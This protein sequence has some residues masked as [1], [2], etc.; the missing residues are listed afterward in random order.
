MRQFDINLKSLI[1]SSP[2]VIFLCKLTG[3]WPVELITENV[4]QFGYETE[5][6]ISG[7]IQFLDIV[8]PEDRKRVNEEITRYSKKGVDKIIQEY[9]ILTA[10]GQIRWVEV[11]AL[12][13]MD[14]NGNVSHYQG[15]LCDATNQ[16]KIEE[17]MQE[18]LKEK[19]EL[20]NIIKSSPV[21]V[22]VCKPA[23]SRAEQK[24]R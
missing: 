17:S 22:F 4:Q 20:R 13:R 16:K 18:T 3:N 8:Y 6:F 14:E 5:D 24:D 7:S 19:N 12:I 2:V 10:S 11:K 23:E 15:T 21:I 1:N 9:R